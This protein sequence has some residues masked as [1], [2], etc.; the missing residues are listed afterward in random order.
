MIAARGKEAD[1][2]SDTQEPRSHASEVK[3]HLWPSL[4]CEYADSFD[5]Y[6]AYWPAN[7]TF[8]HFCEMAIRAGL[9]DST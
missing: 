8:S 1:R 5:G 6:P 7:P 2:E 9:P 4:T 3:V